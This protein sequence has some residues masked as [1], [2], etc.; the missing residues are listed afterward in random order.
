[1]PVNKEWHK[2]HQMPPRATLAQRAAWHLAHA[3]H[4]TSTAHGRQT[5]STKSR[6]CRRG[7]WNDEKDEGSIG[8]LSRIGSILW[9]AVPSTVMKLR[10][11]RKFLQPCA[12]AATEMSRLSPANDTV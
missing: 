12:V 7:S 5:A 10:V 8:C 9:M 1:M 11:N 3:K 6:S 4:S 2:K